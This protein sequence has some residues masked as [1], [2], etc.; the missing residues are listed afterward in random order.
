MLSTMNIRSRVIL[1]FLLIGLLPLLLISILSY[2]RAREAMQ[3]QI[4]DTL[5]MYTETV[6]EELENYYFEREG[7]AEVLSRT[8]DI[9]RSLAILSDDGNNTLS[10]RWQDRLALLHELGPVVVDRFNYSFLYLTSSDGIIVYSTREEL[11]DNDVSRNDYIQESLQNRLSWSDLYYSTLVNEYSLVVSTPVLQYGTR[12]E[13]V[14]TLNL[15]SHQHQI[16]DRIHEGLQTLGERVD[17]YLIDDTGLLLT[18][19]LLGEFS[20]GAILTERITTRPKEVLSNPIRSGDLSFSEALEYIDYLG[21]PVL[22]QM[23][24]TLLGDGPV[25]LVTE[26]DVEEAFAE[27][28]ALRNIMF[29]FGF[30]LLPIVALSSYFLASSFTKPITSLAQLAERVASGD[31]TLN[32]SIEREDEIGSLAKS[33]NTMI[34]TLQRMVQSIRKSAEDTTMSSQELASSTEETSASI[35]EVA[36]S[37]GEFSTT[38]EDLSRNAQD[39][40][41]STQEVNEVAQAGLEQMEETNGQMKEIIHAANEAGT[42]I[43][44]LERSSEDIENITGVILNVA[45]QTNLLALNAAIEAARAG[46]HGQ[47]FAVVAEEV[48]KLAEETQ[49]SVGQIKEIITGLKGVTNTAVDVIEN[50]NH[51]I[52]QGAENLKKTSETFQIIVKQITS[53]AS[54]V[55]SVASAS[56]E[57]SASSQEIAATTEEQSAS[58]EEISSAAEELTAMADE[59]NQLV[60]EI[61]V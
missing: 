27:I 2:Q 60:E 19:T 30:I 49:S 45:D 32:C 18:D 13:V 1:L 54:M 31:L 9:Y 53:V 29:L 17:S 41:D 11:I 25:G 21:N 36:A 5:E 10:Y 26:I 56:E 42:T 52:S 39:M 59:L 47:G 35:E 61:S 34:D 58:M 38:L 50:N 12:G 57:L 8:Q 24:V 55:Q 51:E 43:K 3:N 37:V 20:E 46:E 14:G 4:F 6:S 23:Q 40:S 15:V 33:F 28:L 48:R 16:Q 22:G 7:D 44:G